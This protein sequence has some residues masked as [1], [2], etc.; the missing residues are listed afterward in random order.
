[1]CIHLYN[2]YL[3]TCIYTL[4]CTIFINSYNYL[5]IIEIEK[6]IFFDSP[7]I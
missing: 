7:C 1:M 3:N 5:K 6:K 4:T 2:T